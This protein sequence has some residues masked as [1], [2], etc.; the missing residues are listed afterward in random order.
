M[1]DNP[2]E[3]LPVRL[4]L[5]GIEMVF[6]LTGPQAPLVIAQYTVVPAVRMPGS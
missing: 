1:G 6:E 3:M 4:A 2:P 5:T